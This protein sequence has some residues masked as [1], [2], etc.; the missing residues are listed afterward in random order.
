MN[1][2]PLAM[3]RPTKERNG[4]VY[5][6]LSRLHGFGSYPR[7]STRSSLGIK[8]YS[9]SNQ[10]FT[11]F[12]EFM[13]TYKNP[14]TGLTF[15]QALENLVNSP[16]YRDLPDYDPEFDV[17][18]QPRNIVSR[19][20]KLT[21]L[22]EIDALAKVYRDAT[23]RHFKGT[24]PYLKHLMNQNKILNRKVSSTTNDFPNQVEAWRS[25]VNTDV[26]TM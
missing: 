19:S 1:I 2:H 5:K 13:T 26:R 16:M 3:F 22:A 9:M 6:E 7:F 8:G 21:K 12:R 24:K 10:E 15:A 11:E 25:I 23:V 17:T 18:G 20:A 4:I 14:S